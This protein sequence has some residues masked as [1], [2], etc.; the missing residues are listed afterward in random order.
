MSN[1]VVTTITVEIGGE[2]IARFVNSEDATFFANAANAA[3]LFSVSHPGEVAH[4]YD[5]HG[6]TLDIPDTYRSR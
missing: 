3:G 2:I 4:A 6:N 1:R 5:R